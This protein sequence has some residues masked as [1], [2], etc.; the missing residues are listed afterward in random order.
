MKQEELA[1]EP[2]VR[3]GVMKFT[4]HEQLKAVSDQIPDMT[5]EQLDNW[6]RTNNF[7]SYRSVLKAAYKKLETVS[8]DEQFSRFLSE[9]N[10]IFNFN[11]Q[12]SSLRPKIEIS[13]IQ[14]TVNREG[15]YQTDIYYNRIVGDYVVI[16]KSEEY[17]RLRQITTSDLEYLTN[18]DPIRFFKFTNQE[19]QTDLNARTNTTCPTFLTDSFYYNPSGCRNDRKAFVSAQSYERLYTDPT[20]TYYHPRVRFRVWGEIRNRLCWWN[21]YATLY[22]YRN[23]SFSIWKWERISMTPT[24][25][26]SQ[27]KFHSLSLPDNFVDDGFQLGLTWDKPIGDW[28]F[29]ENYPTS[30]F[31]TVFIQGKS[32]GIGDNWIT[33]SC[34]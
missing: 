15:I 24:A 26:V 27:P 25:S 11:L 19:V 21:Y 14:A 12:D 7:V 29:N 33:I 18:A 32:R 8:N 30:P 6:E 31:T 2:S 28:R 20:G 23:V 16:A 10:D 17:Q 5:E 9:Y 22:E 4:S 1:L 34:P 3:A 13:L